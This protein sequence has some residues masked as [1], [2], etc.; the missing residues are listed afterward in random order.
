MNPFFR[1]MPKNR[2]LAFGGSSGRFGGDPRLGFAKKKSAAK[3]SDVSSNES[4]FSLEAFHSRV[5]PS[6]T[7]QY[8]PYEPGHR[9]SP[10]RTNYFSSRVRRQLPEQDTTSVRSQGESIPF[11]TS[12]FNSTAVNGASSAKAL[13][14]QDDSSEFGESYGSQFVRKNGDSDESEEESEV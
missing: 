11:G 13:G 5:D 9:M 3:N 7:A 10:I 8:D 6:D 12:T 2:T 1:V 14:E 4:N